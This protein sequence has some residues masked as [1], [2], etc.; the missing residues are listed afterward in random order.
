MNQGICKYNQTGFCKFR[1]TCPNFHENEICQ[2]EN[3]SP[4]QCIKRHPKECRYFAEYK[5]C[6][7]RACAFA[8]SERFKQGEVQALRQD[9]E[10]MKHEIGIL[11]LTVKSLTTIRQESEDLK[12]AICILKEDIKEIQ[13]T[14]LNT[15]SKIK[16]L[17]EEF[18]EESEDGDKNEQE[19]HFQ[20]KY[21]KPYSCQYCDIQIKSRKNFEEHKK[22]HTTKGLKEHLKCTKCDY[23]CKRNITLKK[24]FHTKH[25]IE[26]EASGD[27]ESE[28]E[29]EY[30]LFQLEIV[31]DEEVYV[32]NLCDEGL[33]S[34]HEVK[35]HL[36]EK[37]KK[38]FEL[39]EEDNA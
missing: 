10:Y 34:E 9:I 19:N 6:K 16:S 37:H 2:V 14:N 35:E 7:F 3:C 24:H 4:N 30:D 22:I 32:C 12:S 27:T 13:T 23:S 26:N 36:K 17:E 29:G 11:N 18:E 28:S 1:S 38:V 15:E 20:T 25:P 5:Y 39:H 21:E 31:S 8:H 33:D